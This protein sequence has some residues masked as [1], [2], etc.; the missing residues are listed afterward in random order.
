MGGLRSRPAAIA[1][2]DPGLT[3]LLDPG[4]TVT[5][6][7]SWGERRV[8]WGHAWQHATPAYWVSAAKRGIA[9][10]TSF[11]LG[12]TLAEETAACILGGFGLPAAIGLAAFHALRNAS[13]LD[14]APDVSAV[15][16]ILRRP[17]TVA[18]RRVR[19]RFPAQRAARVSAAL[20][21]LTGV[22]PPDGGRPLRDWLLHLPGVGPKTA[23]WI[24][25]NWTGTADVAIIDVHI[26]RAGEVAGV[27]SRSWKIDR[28]YGRYEDHFL[29][30][31]EYGRVHAAVLDSYIWAELA[32]YRRESFPRN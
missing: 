32:S 19:Y 18:G 22:E 27:F 28:D 14:H 20:S 26:R 6:R 23:S 29:A 15:E 17:L 31:A 12:E 10:Q 8:L 9:P 16:E 7:T 25:R 1:P 30:W 13:L 24:A 2:G 21:A 3:Q 11:R 4:E 5:L